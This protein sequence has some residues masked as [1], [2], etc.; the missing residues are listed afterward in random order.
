MKKIYQDMV[1]NDECPYLVVAYQHPGFY[2]SDF[3]LDVIIVKD[4]ITH[5][6]KESICQCYRN[7]G[8]L[9]K[10]CY[11]GDFDMES[12]IILKPM[13]DKEYDDVSDYEKE[14]VRRLI[15]DPDYV[16]DHMIAKA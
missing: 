7:K 8:M 4:N 3:W 9:R 5:F 15:S 14:L 11:I 1:N 2:Y 16:L 13:A 10:L 6:D 12:E